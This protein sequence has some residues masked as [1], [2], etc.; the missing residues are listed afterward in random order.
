MIF[1]E[2][3]YS[4]V[5]LPL[6]YVMWVLYLV[7]KNFG[8][9]VILF[10]LVVKLVSFPLNLKQQRNM[11]VSQ[12]FTPRVQEIQRKH[13]GDNVKLQEEMQKLQKEG[14]NPMGGCG[15]MILIMVILFGVI[16]V[17]YKPMTHLEHFEWADKGSIVKVV[18]IGEETD[19]TA[20]A[21]GSDEDRQLIQTAKNADDLDLLRITDT[22]PQIVFEDDKAKIDPVTGVTAAQR[23]TYGAYIQEHIDF[24]KGKESRLSEP[25]KRELNT[26]HPKYAALQKELTAVQSFAKNPDAFRTNATDPVHI[27]SEV[28]DKLGV[29]SKRMIF[30]GMDLGKQPVLGWDI[31][32]IIPIISFVF[33]LAQ[34]I[35]SQFIQ[36]KTNPDLSKQPGG[37]SMK[38]MLYI[39]P[40]FSL[41][42]AFAVPAGAGFYWA[43]SYLFGIA[44]SIITYK[45]WPPEKMREEARAKNAL[46]L[47]DVVA[48]V[49]VEKNGEVIEKTANLNELSRKEQDEYYRKKLEE[50]RRADRE[51]YGDD[52]L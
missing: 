7:V 11:A 40:V 30:L 32:I 29:L 35:I 44:Q 2:F 19:Y 26:V 49:A 25:L 37:N 52:E 50:A 28:Y 1:I 3:I 4:I 23:E 31:L 16:D 14:Y 38:Y 33:S 46:K 43:V 10:T 21:L 18:D 22:Q 47:P 27:S 36:Q 45:F 6:G 51:K 12:L 13:R 48:T 39:T 15:P 9:A 17:V 42:I 20:L 41:F 5:G 34:M 8:V 24:L